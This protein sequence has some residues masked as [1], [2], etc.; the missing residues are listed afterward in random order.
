GAACDASPLGSIRSARHA[1]GTH[2]PVRVSQRSSTAQL[3]LL[4]QGPRGKAQVCV[5]RSHVFGTSQSR[6]VEQ[7]DGPRHTPAATS[8]VRPGPQLASLAHW[9]HRPPLQ[10]TSGPHTCAAVSAVQP[11]SQAP[12]PELQTWPAAQGDPARQ[13]RSCSQ[14]NVRW[15]HRCPTLQSRLLP[16]IWTAQLRLPTV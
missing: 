6:L 1:P 11:A 7:P 13:P 15:L 2:L 8:Q 4:V 16:Q 3:S 5:A 9:T 10:G 12:V 14:T